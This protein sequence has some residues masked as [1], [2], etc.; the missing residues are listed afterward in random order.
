MKFP[1]ILAAVLCFLASNT[2]SSVIHLSGIT[3]DATRAFAAPIAVRQDPSST[4]SPFPTPITTTT[5]LETNPTEASPAPTSTIAPTPT[6]APNPES[7]FTTKDKILMGAGIV[8]FGI[9]IPIL[10]RLYKNFLARHYEP[11]SDLNPTPFELTESWRQTQ[12]LKRREL[13]NF[14]P[15]EAELMRNWDLHG[16]RFRKNEAY[17]MK[18]RGIAHRQGRVT[19]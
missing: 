18:Q 2:N 4:A 12:V 1:I 8:V 10:Y 5:P 3:N 7:S 14:A 17:R 15:T 6:P 16:Q 9:L 19:F 11:I 13:Q